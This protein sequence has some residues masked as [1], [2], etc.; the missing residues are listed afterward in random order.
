MQTFI[1]HLT[2][3]G[4]QKKTIALIENGSWAPQCIKV[5]KAMLE[6]CKEI[7]LCENN[8]SIKSALTDAN[9]EQIKSLEAELK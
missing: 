4:L 6:G 1:E 9:K 2:E 5:M 8:I 3:R 7:T